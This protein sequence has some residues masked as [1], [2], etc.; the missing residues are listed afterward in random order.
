MER[1]GLLSLP[2]FLR[3]FTKCIP[4]LRRL[5]LTHSRG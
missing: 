2:N 4:V 3:P 1:P 5:A